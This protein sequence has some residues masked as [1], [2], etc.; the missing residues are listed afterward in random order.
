MLKKIFFSNFI[1]VLLSTILVG[2]GFFLI[3]NLLLEV[4]FKITPPLGNHHDFLAFYSAAYLVLHGMIGKIFDA[5]SISNFELTIIPYKVGA[6]GYMPFLNP[7]FV[8]VL[9][10]PL[11]FLSPFSS[12]IIWF[13]LN[14]CLYLIALFYLTKTLQGKTRILS[15]ILLLS[16]FPIY[17]ALIEAQLSI[18]ILVCSVFAINFVKEQRY[19][20]SGFFLSAL[21]IKPQFAIIVVIGLILFRLWKVLFGMIFAGLMIF[22]ITLPL[23]GFGPYLTYINFAFGVF[24]SHFTGAGALNQTAWQGDLSLT[25]GINGLFVAIFGQ[26]STILVNTFTAVVAIVLVSF[27]WLAVTKIKPGF[28]NLGREIMLVVSFIL[29]LLLDPHLYSQDVILLYLTLPL[30]LHRF[31]NSILVV[32]L[33][34]LISDLLLIKQAV[35]AHSFTLILI[36]F[37]IYFCWI[38]INSG[39]AAKS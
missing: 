3:F 28:G 25:A 27:Y 4:F 31:R 10:T 21:W 30:L 6:A 11:A 32:I 12:R 19:F 37:T 26:G 5:T 22:L 36:G 39:E 35:L 18:I 29:I 34:S 17:Q 8:A 7:P 13:F 14:F 23:V 9:L 20:I 33:I 38:S 24:G 2:I 1:L 15:V 16:T